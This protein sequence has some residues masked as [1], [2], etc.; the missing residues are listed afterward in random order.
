MYRDTFAEVSGSGVVGTL[1][2][3]APFQIFGKRL[4]KGPRRTKKYYDVVNLLCVVNLLWPSDSQSRHTLCGHHFLGNYR[5]FSFQ[6]RVHSVV[7]M[8]GLVKTLPKGP[9]HTK[10]AI[11]MEIVVFCYRGSIL[12]SVPI[13]CH[14]SQ[15]KRRPKWTTI[16]VANYYRGSDLL[17]IVFLVRLGPLGTV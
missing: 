15:E 17:P 12:L 7:N 13:R 14:F 5:H 10:N 16:A 8:G 4:P 3:N 1:P 9:F 6:G 2:K 11:A